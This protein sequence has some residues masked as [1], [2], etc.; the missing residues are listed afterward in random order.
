MSL[1]LASAAN[2][3]I[4]GE[5]WHQEAIKLAVVKAGWHFKTLPIDPKQAECVDL[6]TTLTNG[7]YLVVGV[8]NNQWYRGKTKQ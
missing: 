2:S 7:F 8:T 1:K 3:G 4:R 5:Q 6:R